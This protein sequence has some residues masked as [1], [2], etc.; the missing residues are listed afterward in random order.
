MYAQFQEVD[1]GEFVILSRTAIALKHQQ[2]KD[3]LHA[4]KPTGFHSIKWLYRSIIS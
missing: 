1:F 2:V 4:K 3:L